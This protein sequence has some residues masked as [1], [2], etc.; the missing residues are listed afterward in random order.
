RLLER[1]LMPDEPYISEQYKV[2]ATYLPAFEGRS[3]GGDFYDIFTTENGYTGIVIGDVSGKGV[4]A[5]SLAVATRSTVR[6]FGYE[7]QVPGKALTHA[8][9]VLYQQ[10]SSDFGTFV[11]AFL[12]I[13]DTSTGRLTYSS[14][15]HP[16]AIIKRKDGNIDYLN[17]PNP[18][19]GIQKSLSFDELSTFINIG[20][21]MVLYTDGIIEAR[22]GGDIFGL[23][24][25]EYVLNLHDNE[26]PLLLGASLIAEAEKWDGGHLRDDTALI[27][28]ERIDK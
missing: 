9:S 23:E 25:I 2:A 26:S 15:G 7:M 6:A 12:I 16:P 24:R 13:L 19:L 28:I 1:A 17:A 11:T 10:N 18:P 21:K 8:N 27:V 14:A 4:H 3:I 5:V 22:K 20:D